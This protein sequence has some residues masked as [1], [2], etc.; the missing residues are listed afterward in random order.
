MS[1]S[2]TLLVVDINIAN[3][4]SHKLIQTLK[5]L[6]IMKPIMN[7]GVYDSK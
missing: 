6:T 7:E 4:F 3:I 1:K 2:H 5:S